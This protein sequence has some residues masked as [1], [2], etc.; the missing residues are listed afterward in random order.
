MSS[1][2]FRSIIMKQVERLGPARS[3]TI[4]RESPDHLVEP[5]RS[6]TDKPAWQWP[7]LA[8]ILLLTGFL[9]FYKLNLEGY[10][11]TYYAAAVRSMLVSWHNFF[12]VS[13]DPGG[14]VTVDKPP[15][16]FWI[17]TASAWL[18]GFSGWSILAPQ[19]LAGVLSVAAL[20]FLVRRA[21]GAGPAL[22]AALFLA[23]TPITVAT[24]RNN[25]IDG[26]LVL[27]LLLAAAAFSAAASTGKLRWLLLGAVLAG[28]GF[29]VKM[30]EA[31]LPLPAFF[32]VYLIAAPVDWRR[33][34]VH[35]TLAGAV[36]TVVSLSWATAV[37]LVPVDQR[38]YVGSSTDN[39]VVELIVGHNGL[40]RLLP[41]RSIFPG[42]A[43]PTSRPVTPPPSAA[44][45]TGASGSAALSAANNARG[46]GDGFGP[47]ENG[48]P[49][50][51][52]FFSTQLAGQISWLLLPAILGWVV[53]A[54]QIGLKPPYNRQMQ[55]L[56]LFGTWLLTELT[57]FSVASMFHP[58]YMVTL[59]PA[60]AALA[61]TGLVALWREFRRQTGRWWLLPAGIGAT[62]LLQIRF[63]VDFP[64]WSARLAPIILVG[65]IA[66]VLILVISRIQ[67]SRR[68]L[69]RLATIVGTL[70]LLVAPTVWA[71]I[72]VA[73]ASPR[74]NM[75]SAGPTRTD[76]FAYAAA[77]ASQGSNR[78]GPPRDDV[79]QTDPRLVAFLEA[80]SANTRFLV[81]TPNAMSA[82]PIILET[83][84]PVMALGGFMGSDPILTPDQLAKLVTS[85]NVRYF[86]VPVAQNGASGFGAWMGGQSALTRW[87]VDHGK[88][89][90]SAQWQSSSAT[91]ST[92]TD[93][94]DLSFQL[95]DC[96]TS[97]RPGASS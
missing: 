13:F 1:S 80:N 52:R 85:G 7:A 94:P 34:L 37:D 95:Y 97:A 61:G 28:V 65:A 3:E 22:L 41:G 32:L 54:R 58:Y 83:G 45:T 47:F 73:N 60:I 20:F 87:V 93:R 46:R 91:Q 23:L 88:P 2:V 62:A 59:A 38:P 44:S 25:T 19:A 17:Q 92:G 55:A 84:K 71:A 57:F 27:V 69:V 50:P 26:T 81:A 78:G 68:P 76:L 77:F 66:T 72:P 40:D 33:R 12:F 90:P 4:S 43:R 82:A 31:F 67:P 39:S 53:L 16:G 35:L 21:F 5:I 42:L 49:G 6:V 63:L 48:Q 24:D 74:S 29:N 11:N 30:L 51:L 36:L 10:A 96:G 15:V 56:I 70:T 89:V 75:P 8:A 9:D 79:A 64:S 86:L 14:F 18:F